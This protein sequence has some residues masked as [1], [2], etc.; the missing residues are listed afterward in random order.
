MRYVVGYLFN[1]DLTQVL[2]IR[3]KRPEWQAGLLN[4]VGGKCELGEPAII[5]MDREFTEETGMAE[6]HWHQYMTLTCKTDP[7]T[8]EWRS[9][10]KFFWA[11]GDPRKAKTVSD[12][13]LV[14]LN[15]ENATN[16]DDVISNLPWTLTMARECAEGVIVSYLVTH[17]D[18]TEGMEPEW[19]E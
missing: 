15:V 4:G 17:L 10:I 12:E 11:I 19:A 5:S 8:S 7:L 13:E 18:S 1:Q 9:Q 2:L 16:R 3:K 6:Q 14:V